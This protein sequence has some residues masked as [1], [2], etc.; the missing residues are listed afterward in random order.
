[1]LM[2]ASTF[3]HTS[4]I[5]DVCICSQQACVYGGCDDGTICCWNV[6]SGALEL[7]LT[8]DDSEEVTCVTLNSDSSLLA[9]GLSNGCICLYRVQWSGADQIL[10][11]MTTF[12]AS[13]DEINRLSFQHKNA[14][15]AAVDDNGYLI[16]YDMLKER[17]SRVLKSG[18]ENVA[19]AVQC[20]PAGPWDVV[21]GGLD[22]TAV[23][24]YVVINPR[25]IKPES[26]V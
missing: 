18:H 7:S 17:V 4:G 2:R 20:R 19:A 1:M 3:P 8:V 16:I 6:E 23:R 21:T 14:F 22:A 13:D 11:P 5:N 12:V 10:E 25:L 9:A 15:L 24:W 26:L